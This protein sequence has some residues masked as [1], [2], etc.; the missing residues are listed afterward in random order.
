[1]PDIVDALIVL[2][3][4]HE[5][6]KT[7]TSNAIPS[8]LQGNNK[9]LAR[10]QQIGMT[11]KPSRRGIAGPAPQ[12]ANW[13]HTNC[14]WVSSTPESAGGQELLAAC[15]AVTTQQVQVGWPMHTCRAVALKKTVRIEHP[16]VTHSTARSTQHPTANNRSQLAFFCCHSTLGLHR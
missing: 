12:A 15:H 6:A 7:A 4:N 1:M 16:S 9:P 8:H 11:I 3:P 13:P 14:S 5:R 2:L 10:Q